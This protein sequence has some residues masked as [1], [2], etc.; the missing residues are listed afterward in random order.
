M[1]LIPNQINTRQ[2]CSEVW[3]LLM[4]LTLV[5][6]TSAMGN[7]YNA[8]QCQATFGGGVQSI[9]LGSRDSKLLQDGS[10]KIIGAGQ[11][12]NFKK[13][14]GQY[15][16]PLGG[17]NVANARC[18]VSGQTATALTLPNQWNNTSNN[19]IK[20]ETAGV[21]VETLG[22]TTGDYANIASFG[23]L[24]ANIN[25]RFEFETSSISTFYM[26]KVDMASG[27]SLLLKPGTYWI[28]K[29]VLNSATVKAL[30]TGDEKVTLHIKQF[31]S[32]SGT[33]N[34]AHGTSTANMDIFVHNY[35]NGSL[36]LNSTVAN[37]L[38]Y[39]RGKTTMTGSSVFNG[40][41]TSRVLLMQGTSTINA[42]LTDICPSDDNDDNDDNDNNDA[43]LGSCSALFGSGLQGTIDGSTLTIDKGTII[44][45]GYEHNFDTINLINNEAN[46]NS[47]TTQ[48]CEVTNQ[49]GPQLLLEPFVHSS[50]SNDVHVQSQSKVIGNSTNPLQNWGKF[51]VANGH[52][53]TFHTQTRNEYYI[54]AITV[55]N[56]STLYLH[57]GIYWIG[58][59]KIESGGSLVLA[60]D[61]VVTMHADVFQSKGEFNYQPPAG[62]EIQVAI[63]NAPSNETIFDSGSKTHG[64]FYVNGDVKLNSN[65][66]LKGYLAA[67]NV[68]MRAGSLFIGLAPTLNGGLCHVT[69]VASLLAHYR[70][71]ECAYTN[72]VNQVIDSL[73]NY[74]GTPQNDITVTSSDVMGNALYPNGNTE[75]VSTAIPVADDYSVSV[76][77]KWPLASTGNQYQTLA[78]IGDPALGNSDPSRG[79]L[80]VVDSSNNFQLQMWKGSTQY[81][82]NNN[83]ALGNQNL[84][85][86]W[87]HLTLVANKVDQRSELYIDKTLIDSFDVY[88]GGNISRLVSSTYPSG[89][90]VDAE[91]WQGPIDELMIFTGR[92]TSVLI[93]NIYDNQSQQTNYD[94]S[95]Y[96]EPQCFNQVHHYLLTY[97]AAASSCQVNQINVKACADDSCSQ[98]VTQSS[99]FDLSY[100]RNGVSSTL[101]NGLTIPANQVS[102][103]D[104][105]IPSNIVGTLTWNVLQA[106]PL[107]AGTPGFRCA[108]SANCQMTI[109]DSLNVRW[110]YDNQVINIP[111]Q[112]AEKAFSKA[113]KLEPISACAGYSEKPPLS[114]GYLCVSPAQCSNRTLTVNGMTI[115]VS[116]DA[117]A[118]NYG[119][120]LATYDVNNPV[121]L[122]PVIFN[123]AGS[124]RL[125]AKL[126]DKE[127]PSNDFS[128]R[129]AEL[130]L[131]LEEISQDTND[132]VVYP[133][134]PYR[135]IAGNNYQLTLYSLG[136]VGKLNPS[137]VNALPNYRAKSV[138]ASAVRL[139]PLNGV[140][141][142][143]HLTNAS[144]SGSS[145][146]TTNT[147]PQEVN[148]ALLNMDDQIDTTMGMS[149]HL[150]LAYTEAG[151]FSLA[152]YDNYDNQ[153]VESNVLTLGSYIPAYFDVTDN[154]PALVDN[155]EVFSYI[156]KTVAF[157]STPSIT[158]TAY[159]SLG[160]ET[161]NYDTPQGDGDLW[162]YSPTLSDITAADLSG[163]SGN[164]T[165]NLN[166]IDTF[167]EPFYD[168]KRQYQ[169][170]N[171]GI[172]YQKIPT[173]I[174]PFDAQ[175]SLSFAVVANY[176]N[177]IVEYKPAGH[178]STAQSKHELP[179]IAGTKMHWGRVI[180]ENAYGSELTDISV[181]V[182]TQTFAPSE[183][184]FTQTDDS[185]HSYD[186]TTNE[187]QLTYTT[188]IANYAPSA[189][190]AGA[191]DIVQGRS[192]RSQ[193]LIAPAPG[194]GATGEILLRLHFPNTGMD[195]MNFD[196]DDNGII[197]A[198]DTP[199]SVIQFG[200]YRGN[201][202]II[203]RRE[204]F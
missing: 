190:I 43:E 5:F 52:D 126:G 56:N 136:D 96:T 175:V 135:P 178:S 8:Q 41:I 110:T 202:R 141:G 57:P 37:G 188:D 22:L 105:L 123:D 42:E 179:P 167:A 20:L 165:I 106:N 29:L 4:L 137:I 147:P 199:Q 19:S 185:C 164:A 130:R 154:A 166:A 119:Q 51:N 200:H 100:T 115:P 158:V 128:V 89:S 109:S 127:V 59:L 153:T 111:G 80:L 60:G 177:N 197:D 69:P 83:I 67:D 169:L 134:L 72:G 32:N 14:E 180:L 25:D 118:I 58:N 74:H 149:E 170:N 54:K 2:Y 108:N 131:T 70:F 146:L 176:S 182:V 18:A 39:N 44:N 117:T 201:D 98:V 203:N 121:A 26:K 97:S 66:E 113:L 132:P 148:L 65:S 193:G 46:H 160:D 144:I 133:Q 112:I 194:S 173:P 174:V 40:A 85:T 99:S 79:K 73:G 94:G 157:T 204:G 101:V 93:A 172:V 159:N 36:K 64:F 198:D 140:D 45:A 103:V 163:Y 55:N 139:S 124:I 33:V 7:V 61:G 6:S 82:G 81:L 187:P 75:Y 171:S 152:F 114:V 68:E 63:H 104:T 84:S 151:S 47:C 150:Q 88:V 120:V 10:A 49:H 156:G 107:P 161:F 28:D 3:L 17:C 77:F 9:T 27:S 186:W 92:L 71:D 143:I 48:D 50:V 168:G 191:G 138:T 62:R 15:N 86:G 1:L 195:Y 129:P 13:S 196:W 116:T 162:K 16:M 90:H 35:G 23:N 53:L 142:S 78:S 91:L 145:T 184:F 31:I 76:W 87:H 95:S 11:I 155:C 21:T 192:L 122:S 12:L 30:T 38:I 181:P 125:Y 102:G 183:Q 34:P 24:T 189:V